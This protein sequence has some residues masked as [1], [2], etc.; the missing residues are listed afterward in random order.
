[1]LA[2]KGLGAK[3]IF[4]LL[5]LIFL[6]N[7]AWA[8]PI[9]NEDG[10]IAVVTESQPQIQVEEIELALAVVEPTELEI[11]VQTPKGQVFKFPLLPTNEA[12]KNLYNSMTEDEQKEF[13]VNRLFF[14][15]RL[16]TLL[17]KTGWM[18]GSGSL[19]KNKFKY[20]FRKNKSN[21]AFENLA[22]DSLEKE[23][24]LKWREKVKKRADEM[25]QHFLET[26]DRYL[27]SQSKIVAKQ[28]EISFTASLGIIAEAGV[29]EKG[30]GGS[31]ALGINLG[32]NKDRQA[33]VFE[34]YSEVESFRKAFV[35]T[36]M[37]A[38][39]P[40]VGYLMKMQKEDED[41]KSRISMSFY[42]PIVPSYVTTSS[43]MFVVGFNTSL[44]SFPPFIGDYFSYLNSNKRTPIIRLSFSSMTKPFVSPGLREGA[45]Y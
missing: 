43:E 42:P 7:T 21:E 26:T 17:E 12:D 45:L 8:E 39:V 23:G 10:Q 16:A 30:F 32:Y 11:L 38:S 44:L 3:V 1:M 5:H 28:N 33:L 4:S 41:L 19:I 31:F 25:T 13:Q 18:L 24:E 15:V 20:L 6:V 34:I 2:K 36:F 37:I 14:L 27:W 9:E 22:R 35:P 40:K 29:K